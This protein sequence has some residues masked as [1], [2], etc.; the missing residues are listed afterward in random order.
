MFRARSMRAGVLAVASLLTL[1]QSAYA[2]VDRGT[3]TYC[4]AA[5]SMRDFRV[6]ELARYIYWWQD[7]VIHEGAMFRDG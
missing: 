5:A 4:H 7:L 1:T 2:Q 3:I 6:H